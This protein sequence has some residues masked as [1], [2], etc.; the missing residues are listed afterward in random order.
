MKHRELSAFVMVGSTKEFALD[1]TLS[2]KW[3][4]VCPDYA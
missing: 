1:L 2:S 3:F 4:F